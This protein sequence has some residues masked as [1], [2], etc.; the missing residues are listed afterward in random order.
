M[1]LIEFVRAF[2]YTAVQGFV[3][4]TGLLVVATTLLADLLNAWLD[5]RANLK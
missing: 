3:A 2:D 5:P 4:L 1:S